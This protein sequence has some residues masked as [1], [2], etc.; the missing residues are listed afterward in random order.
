[1]GTI[2]GLLIFIGV[3]VVMNK[4]GLGCCGGHGTKS[5]H[6]RKLQQ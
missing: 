2:A 3:M 6:L 1:M 5:D 4:L